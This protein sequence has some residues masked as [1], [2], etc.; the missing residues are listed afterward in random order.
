MKYH[1]GNTMSYSFTTKAANKAA[2]KDAV[3]SE[4]DKVVSSQPIHARDRAAV[5]ANANAVIDQLADDDTKDVTVSCNG[6]LSWN[7]VGTFAPETAPVST[8][9]VGCSAGYTTRT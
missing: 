5:L 3:A 1:K 8:V 7:G 4:F 6:Y 2:A 9:S